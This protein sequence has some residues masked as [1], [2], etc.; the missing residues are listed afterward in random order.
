M[1]AQ[2]YIEVGVSLLLLVFLLWKEWLRQD[3]SRLAG[4]VAAT[5]VAVVA[6]VGIV[7]PPSYYRKA[8]ALPKPAVVSHPV[9][10]GVVGVD[11]QRRL[12]KGERLQVQGKWAGKPVKLLLM[13]LGSVM[14]SVIAG[15]DFS[16]GTVPVQ[17]GRALYQLVAVSG[18]DTLEREDIPVQVEAGKPLKILVLAAAPGF[19]NTFLIN[20]LAS[21]GQQVASRTAVSTNSYQSSYRSMVPRPLDVLTPAL[22]NGFDVV[23]ADSSALPAAGSPAL[24]VLRRQVREKGLGLVIRLDSAD[25]EG[26][27]TGW[28]RVGL[29][30]MARD[31]SRRATVAGRLYGSGKVVFTTLNATY[32]QMMKGQRQ[33]YAAYW[34]TVLRRV[35][36]ETEPGERWQLIPALPR[37]GEP[38][39]TVVQTDAAAPVQG[40]VEAEDGGAPINIYM[41][42]GQ[43]LPFEW[44]G[45]Y[46]P[47]TAGWQM[48]HTLKGD[49]TWVYFWPRSAWAALYRQQRLGAE[50]R[51]GAGAG[52]GARAGAAAAP[53]LQEAVAIPAYWFYGLFLVSVLFLWVERKMAGMNG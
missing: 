4:R 26:V 17:A 20:W 14:D 36:R 51:N 15:G 39:T 41:V 23:I 38:V 49:T 42:E 16:L 46:W 35:S 9:L 13:G 22:L 11:W 53:R 6:L 32:A 18:A 12:A 33:G 40:V 10:M 34:S 47:V 24:T 8:V 7:L 43:V 2:A 44:R 1:I 19:E 37:V 45:T 5:V 31:S 50:V 30:V 52:S 21:D 29:R 48:L 28:G 27:N 25:P 3:R